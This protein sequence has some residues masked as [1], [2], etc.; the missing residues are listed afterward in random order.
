M[1]LLRV[2]HSFSRQHL[3]TAQ[4]FAARALELEVAELGAANP[5]PAAQRPYVTGAIVFAIA[6]LES[7]INELF[8]EAADRNPHSM[9][10][11]PD[12]VLGRIEALWPSLE[13]QPMLK[14]YQAAVALAD[15][16]PIDPG[17]AL[18]ADLTSL[19]KLRDALLH[20]K[21]EWDDEA[22]VHEQLRRRLTGRFPNNPLAAPGSLWFP[23]LCLSSGCAHWAVHLA[24]SFST[25]FISTLGVPER[26]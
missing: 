8:L 3:A 10:G 7:S 26:L 16:H 11:L 14:K 12:P 4:H 2:K 23:H 25:R 9:G 21:P 6:A 15:K 24:K 19:V 13:M 5:D 22:E 17:D 20:F 1:A 18:I